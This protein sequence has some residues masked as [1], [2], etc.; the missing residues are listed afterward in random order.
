MRYS[1]VVGAFS[2]L[3]ATDPN[4]NSKY[5]NVYKFRPT[6]LA[7]NSSSYTTAIGVRGAG[8]S[9]FTV[10]HFTRNTR[11][12]E[13]ILGFYPNAFSATVLLEKYANAFDTPG[14]NW[15]YGAGGHIAATNNKYQRK[16]QRD[17]Y[18]GYRRD[19]GD[20]GLGVDGIVGIEYKINEIPIAISLD[21]KP[22]LEVTT[23][24]NIFM[25]LDPGLGIK[26]TF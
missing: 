11:A 25:A 4:H 22:F 8:T 13:G 24:G 16:Y 19:D 20:I 3:M 14:L 2:T 15:Y 10:K 21:A 1:M 23:S 5:L 7:L 17:E 12:I 18:W 6:N 9:G 26:V